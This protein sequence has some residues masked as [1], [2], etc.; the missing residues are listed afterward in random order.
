[1]TS[2]KIFACCS[3]NHQNMSTQHIRNFN[4]LINYALTKVALQTDIQLFFR[5]QKCET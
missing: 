2:R 1:M 5:R 3:I 4:Q